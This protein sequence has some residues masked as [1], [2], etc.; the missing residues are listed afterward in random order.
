MITIY[1][2]ILLDTVYRGL[3]HYKWKFLDNIETL[4]MEAPWL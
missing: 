2:Y 1:H 3:H 4:K